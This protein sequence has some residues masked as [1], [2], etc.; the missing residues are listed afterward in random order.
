MNT[1]LIKRQILNK[2]LR[3]LSNNRI[4]IIVGARQVGKT[5]LL[6]LIKE[7]LNQKTIL[8]LN[9]EK[10]SDQMHLVD[11]ESFSYYLKNHNA[12]TKEAIIFIDEFQKISHPTKLLKLIYDE[13]P[14]I[15]IIATGSSSLEIYNHLSEESLAGRKRI[16]NLFALSFSEFLSFRYSEQK[17][18]WQNM[19]LHNNFKAPLE[20]YSAWNDFVVWGGY[21]KP[22]LI[23]NEEERRE[24]LDEIYNA[25]LEKDVAGLLS[26]DEKPNFIKLTALLAS[27]IG[28]LLNINE[29]ANTLNLA[30]STIERFLYLLQETFIIKLVPPFFT[31][32]RKE[33]TKMP[34]IYFFDTGLKNSIRHDFSSL[35]IRPDNGSL[36]ENF[37]LI[38]LLKYSKV[39]H[40]FFFWRTPHGTETDFILKH[41]QNLFPIEV[42]YKF[43]KKPI[44]PSGLKAFINNYH[45]QIKAAF[46]LTKDFY[47][48]TKYNDVTVYFLPAVLTTKIFDLIKNT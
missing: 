25:Y 46:V 39:W 7:K 6:H 17:T 5:S 15:K 28:N 45:S 26:K 8:S 3:L 42:K 48:Q 14:Q 35:D 47:A 29:L 18:I 31:N 44:V 13:L 36:V 4:L 21:P 23:T 1:K 30:R 37:V 41:D 19:L 9:A 38:E 11:F 24:E 20:I 12:F 2:I 34:K 40:E 33:L 43:F 27:Q 32:K 16:I 22:S 10:A